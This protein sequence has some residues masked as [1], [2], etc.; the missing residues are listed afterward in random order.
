M[1]NFATKILTFFLNNESFKKLQ[2]AE[3][4][5]CISKGLCSG[6]GLCSSKRLCSSRIQNHFL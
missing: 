6:K 2:I 4:E 5:L 1:N 3:K